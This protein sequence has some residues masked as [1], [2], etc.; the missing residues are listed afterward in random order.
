VLCTVREV[1]QAQKRW[2]AETP[3]AEAG[4]GEPEQPSWLTKA[5]QE[6]LELQASLQQL[7]PR[8]RP[9]ICSDS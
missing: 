7:F 6:L 8:I 5:Q 1:A 3:T 9:A 2:R 4:A